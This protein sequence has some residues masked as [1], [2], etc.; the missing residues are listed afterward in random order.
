[1]S[2]STGQSYKNPGTIEFD[3][4]IKD[5]GSGGAF[6][7][8]PFDVEQLFGVKG[9]VPIRVMF[10]G[11]AYRGSLAKMSQGPHMIGILKATRRQL[12]KQPGDTVHVAVTLDEAPRVVVLA[13]DIAQ[14][15]S[16]AGVDEL[17][18][19]LAYSHQR[20]YAR[21]IEDAKQAETRQRRIEKAID[22]IRAKAP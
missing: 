2:G 7:E 12:G 15:F 21:W 6:V 3:A 13:P 20:E 16:V 17:Y 1:M 10:D 11:G 9:R 18:R 8:F 19:A 22:M 4:I 5:A 14:A